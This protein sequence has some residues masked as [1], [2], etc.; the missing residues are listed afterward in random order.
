LLDGDTLARETCRIIVY[1]ARTGEKTQQQKNTHT[2]KSSTKH[3]MKL[4]P[5]NFVV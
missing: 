5:E 4:Q 2:V 1:L 3:S